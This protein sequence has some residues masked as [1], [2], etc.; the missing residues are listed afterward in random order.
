MGYLPTC[1]LVKLTGNRYAGYFAC[2]TT[3]PLYI[4]GQSRDPLS[5]VFSLDMESRRAEHVAELY[6][7]RA[8]AT[9]GN[10][11]LGCRYYPWLM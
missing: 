7:R 4:G 10:A 3:E 5:V 11:P 2:H 1:A 8:T 9:R 6:R